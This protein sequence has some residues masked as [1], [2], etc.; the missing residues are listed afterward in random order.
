MRIAYLTH[1]S[2]LFGANRSLLD[3]MLEARR[4]GVVEP[5]VV[6]P[7]EGPFT[8]RLKQEG[9]PYAVIPFQPWMSERHYEGGP[10]HR[11]RQWFGHTRA[12]WERAKT[13]ARL[14]PR[15]RDRLKEWNVQLVH[16]NSA[17]VGV[18]PHLIHARQWPVVW[19]IRELPE[20]QYLLH[21]DA[22]A[23]AYGRWLRK[24]TRRIAISQAVV[25]DIHRYAGTDLAIDLI[26]NGVLHQ[27]RYDE[28]RNGPHP[29]RNGPFTFLLLGLIHPNKGQVEAV[30]ALARV[31]AEGLDARLVIAG[32]GRDKELRRRITELGLEHAVDLPGFVQDVWPLLRTSDA[33]LMASRNEAMGRVTVE[34]MAAALPVVGHASGGTLELVEDGV[35]GLYYREGT[36]DLAAAMAALVRDPQRAR[37][38]GAAGHAQARERFSVERMTDAV[39]RVYAE[40]RP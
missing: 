8:E 16:L 32:K 22:G 33:L 1:Y 24:A 23:K 28:E 10:H 25:E 30:E 27:A 17:A 37:D 29:P 15:L 4:R 40:V 18:A 5:H 38:M 6:L 26:Y 21:I 14:W 36:N 9:I 2:E 20:R 35:T 31:R 3:L 19:H 7:A 34:A 13:N 39:L 12:A 11:L